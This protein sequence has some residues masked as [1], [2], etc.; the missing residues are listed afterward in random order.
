MS[1]GHSSLGSSDV[2]RFAVGW[3][4]LRAGLRS[5]DFSLPQNRE[6]L[7]FFLLRDDVT[8]RVPTAH[9]SCPCMSCWMLKHNAVSEVRLLSC[10]LRLTKEQITQLLDTF[11]QAMPKNI[12]VADAIKYVDGVNHDWM[13]DAEDA[14]VVCK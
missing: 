10:R 3:S 11:K 6:R 13:D 2:K 4:K 5:A 8:D 12:R 14:A 7:Y 1:S 9:V